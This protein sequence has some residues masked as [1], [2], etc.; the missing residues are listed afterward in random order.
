MSDEPLKK[1]LVLEPEQ[2]Y[3]FELDPG[4]SL[5][6]KASGTSLF[7]SQV[8]QSAD[9]FVMYS[10]YGDKPRYLELNLRRERRTSL[11][12]NARRQCLHGKVVCWR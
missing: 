3:R 6:I 8:P 4:I 10:S 9:T 12:L 1:E 2:E 5:A 11:G 7:H